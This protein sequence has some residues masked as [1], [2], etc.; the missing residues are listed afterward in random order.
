LIT[1]LLGLV[2]SFIFYALAGEVAANLFGQGLPDGA[3][4]AVISIGQGLAI[5]GAVLVLVVGA[6]AVAGWSAG[7]LDPASVLREAGA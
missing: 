6:A 3:A 1:A 2:L 4:L 7:R 5:C